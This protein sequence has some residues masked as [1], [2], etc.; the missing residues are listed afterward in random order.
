MRLTT[1]RCFPLLPK[2]IGKRGWQRGLAYGRSYLS[3][4]MHDPLLDPLLNPLLCDVLVEASLVT[5]PQQEP[6]AN[7]VAGSVDAICTTTS[8]AVQLTSL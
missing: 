7:A 2:E 3:L 8:L 6:I 1:R 5:M 4:S